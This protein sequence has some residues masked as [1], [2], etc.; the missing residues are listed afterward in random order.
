MAVQLNR[1]RVWCETEQIYVY[2]W[3][4]DTISECPNNIGHTIDTDSISIVQSVGDNMVSISELTDEIGRPYVRVDSRDKH[5]DT[6]FTSACDTW[7]TVT[8]EVIGTADGSTTE[9][10][11][12]NKEVRNVSIEVDGESVSEFSVDYSQFESGNQ[13]INWCQGKVTFDTAPTSGQITA[14]Y[15]YAEIAGGQEGI[16][17]FSVDQGTTK[18]IDFSFCDPVHIKDGLICFQNGALDSMID[19]YVVCPQG[20]Y[21]SK[22]DGSYGIAGSGGQLIKHY[23][24]HHRLLG[25]ATMGIYA[26]TETRSLAI[27]IGYI[28]RMVITKGSATDSFKG[29]IRLEMN[30]ERTVII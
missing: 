11:L 25:D 2:A 14:S 9:F 26:N 27:P 3:S 24:Q 13:V 18:T 22:N 20:M 7:H 15:E 4:E 10:T 5:D 28:I 21:Y 6:Y 29:W 16:W 19:M 1:Y 17:D 30:R 23:V 8:D 12:A